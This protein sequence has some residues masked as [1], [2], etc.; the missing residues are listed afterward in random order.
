MI[1][2]NLPSS[3]NAKEKRKKALG[4]ISQAVGAI[5]LSRLSGGSDISDEIISSFDI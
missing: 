5:L 4:L 1:E 2:Q 3:L